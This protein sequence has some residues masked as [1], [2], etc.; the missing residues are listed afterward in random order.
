[1]THTTFMMK[2]EFLPNEILIEC[3]EYLNACEIFYSFD[4]LNNRFNQLIRHIPLYIDFENVN[5]SMFNEFCTKMLLDSEIKNQVY[6]VTCSS[7]TLNVKIKIADLFFFKLQTLSISK[8]DSVSLNTHQTSFITKLKL[9]EYYLIEFEQLLVHTPMLKY[10]YIR[11]M[12]YAKDN[13]MNQPFENRCYAHL[14]KLV[15]N[16]FYSTFEIFVLFIKQTPNL[17]H[18]SISDS[19]AVDMIDADQWEQ[20]IRSSLPYLTVFKFIFDNLSHEEIPDIMTKLKQFQTDFWQHEHQWFTESAE[21]E[22]FVSIFTIPYFKNTFKLSPNGKRYHNNLK[23]YV[24]AFQNVTELKLYTEA[25]TDKC[26][27]YFPNVT[28]L[29]LISDNH[30]RLTIEHI[31]YLKKMV[32][33]FNLKCLDISYDNKISIDLPAFLILVKEA[34]QLLSLT[35]YW[36]SLASFFANN[37]LCSYLNKMIKTLYI[38]NDECGSLDNYYDTEKF[39]EVFSN[40][41]YLQF[42]NGHEDQLLFLFNR[43]PKL[44]TLAADWKSNKKSGNCDR[45]KNRIQKLNLIYDINTELYDRNI[46]IAIG[47]VG[48]SQICFYRTYLRVWFGN[49]ISE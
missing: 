16:N 1:M 18:L 2:F 42:E 14:K 40:V 28:D 39:C 41:I 11:H 7:R 22:D 3:L 26:Q 35:I 48:R 43:L 30:I 46:D 19:D 34:Q 21:T 29:R 4:Q 8:L 6:F 33:L 15:V 36:N 17:K 9:S 23:K 5:K 31:E 13:N 24:D 44:V 47:D 12:Y 27:Y 38:Y 25:I 20:L 37:E 32:N 49:N 45:F 10:L